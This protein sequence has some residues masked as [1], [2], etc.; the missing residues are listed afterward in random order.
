MKKNLEKTDN[1]I[2]KDIKSNKKFEAITEL[3]EKSPLLMKVEKPAELKEEVYKRE[4]IQTTG[5][6]HGIAIAHA[7][8]K[9]AK[10]LV[11]VL[12]I[13]HDGVDYDSMDGE[14]VHF[15]FMVVHP[16][17]CQEQYMQILSAIGKMFCKCI[18]P[19]YNNLMNQFNNISQE[20]CG[21]FIKVIS[22]LN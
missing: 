10:K 8:T 15:L 16:P 19:N 1:L 2:V 14:P 22:K 4:R 21:E 7:N 13:S 18:K 3:F 6:G 5:L 9:K 20:L 11:F 12:G 17:E